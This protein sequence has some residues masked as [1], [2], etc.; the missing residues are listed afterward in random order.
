MDIIDAADIV[1][2]R[3]ASFVANRLRGKHRCDYTPHLDCGDNVVIINAEKIALTGK[4]L[5]DKKFYWHTGYPGGIKETNA[6]KTLTGKFPERLIQRAVKRMIPKGPLGY[7][8][9]GNLR[10]YAGGDHPHSAQSPKMVD[11]GSL[12]TKNKR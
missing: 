7:A 2:G 4:K 1:L 10:V 8:Q 9:L 11:F 6:E 3:L 5:Q 12:N